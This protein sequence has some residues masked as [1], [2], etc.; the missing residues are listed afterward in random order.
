MPSRFQ[1]WPPPVQGRVGRS[2]AG[3]GAGR[4]KVPV[5]LAEELMLDPA[6]PP[7]AKERGAEGETSWTWGPG[8]EPEHC[9]RRVSA[10]KQLGEEGREGSRAGPRVP[11]QRVRTPGLSLK[12]CGPGAWSHP[13]AQA[14][15][16]LPGRASLCSRQ[17][18]AG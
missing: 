8:Q 1:L 6:S 9:P 2:E 10:S 11:G 5:A 7:T 17:Q 15:M 12:S 14:G 13:P 16:D 3:G 18:C 4:G